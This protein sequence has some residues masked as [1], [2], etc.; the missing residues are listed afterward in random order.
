MRS[1]QWATGMRWSGKNHQ[2]IRKGWNLSSK[3]VLHCALV[4]TT[5]QHIID[6]TWKASFLFLVLLFSYSFYWCLDKHKSLVLLQQS[7]CGHLWTQVKG[8][9]VHDSPELWPRS[10]WD[11]LADVGSNM[12]HPKQA[13]ANSSKR[14]LLGGSSVD[15]ISWEETHWETVGK[16]ETWLSMSLWN[17]WL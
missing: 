5:Q 3:T 14:G 9:P 1:R 10:L 17:I 12:F 8:H 15:S 6:E 2:S 11:F 4:V 7:P 13:Q 16:K